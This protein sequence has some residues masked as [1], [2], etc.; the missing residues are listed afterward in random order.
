MTKFRGG[1]KSIQLLQSSVEQ[2]LVCSLIMVCNDSVTIHPNTGFQAP[3]GHRAHDCTPRSV[4]HC[5]PG[6]INLYLYIYIYIMYKNQDMYNFCTVLLTGRLIETGPIL[7]P[8]WA[9]V[10]SKCFWTQYL[11]AQDSA[12]KHRATTRVRLPNIIA[13]YKY[14]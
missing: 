7:P 3:H 6:Y 4:L 11:Q 8:V 5:V 10:W 2:M 14:Q 12:H 1:Q 13:S 9:K